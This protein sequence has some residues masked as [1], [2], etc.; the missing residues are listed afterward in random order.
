MLFSR[1]TF[2][3][4]PRLLQEGIDPVIHLLLQANNT[5]LIHHWLGRGTK[6]AFISSFP[7][8]GNTWMRYMLTDVLLQMKGV[9]TTTSLPV[10]PDNLIAEY[11]RNSMTRRIARCPQWAQE[12]SLAFVKTHA[13]FSRLRK[14]FVCNGEAVDGKNGSPTW[15]CKAI[16]LYRSP[17]DALVSL[18]HVKH[19][20]R[21]SHSRSRLTIDAFCLKESEAWVENI[22]SYI[23][24][25]DNGH[26]VFFISYE[27]MLESPSVV[28]T[29]LL[30]WLG[31][32]HGNQMVQRAVSNMKFCNLQ[33][34]ERQENKNPYPA[35]ENA[36]FFRRG[37]SGSGRSELQ[38]STLQEIRRRTASLVGEAEQRRLKQIPPQLA[39]GK[40][41]LN[42][43]G[44]QAPLRNGEAKEAEISLRLQRS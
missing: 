19:H 5:A 35:D 21:Y 9:E 25:A 1:G 41:V 4:F 30:Q 22:R 14:T 38:E 18:H 42:L 32:P 13:S 44:A 28:L 20:D 40:V 34:L 17:E 27:E 16:Y 29:Q 37:R 26:P 7:R 23:R 3:Q 12:P 15:D 6:V 24:A 39:D 10:K 33:A 43:A 31:A 2:A 8:S 11:C 36:L